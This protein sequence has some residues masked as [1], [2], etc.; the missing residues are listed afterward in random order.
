MRRQ[1]TEPRPALWGWGAL[2]SGGREANVQSWAERGRYLMKLQVCRSSP[3]LLATPAPICNLISLLCCNSWA[4][5]NSLVGALSGRILLIS[6]L[7]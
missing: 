7:V 3:H 6:K 1:A 5:V 2:P 4:G